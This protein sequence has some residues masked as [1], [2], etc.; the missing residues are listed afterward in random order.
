MLR[1]LRKS[2]RE[3]A[4][5]S[6]GA[7]VSAGPG[8]AQAPQPTPAPPMP[9]LGLLATA[10]APDAAV[11]AAM[12]AKARAVLPALAT[13]L[14]RLDPWQLAAA[15]APARRA[16]VRAQVG[17]GKTAVLAHRV[18]WLH[19]VH[20]VALERMAVTTFTTR[21]AA[22]LVDRLT[23]LLPEPP[24]AGAFRLFGTLHGVART[25]LLGELD[26]QPTGWRA[27]FGVL[28]E[29]SALDMLQTL[30]RRH[31]LDVKYPAQWLARLEALR[32]GRPV[33]R[34]N[35]RA[36]DDLAQL[37]ERYADE[38]RAQ[39]VMDFADLIA[40]AGDCV[41]RASAPLLAALVV[42]ELQDC[43]PAEVAL[44][45][46]L[47]ARS[48]HFFAVG[49]PNQSIYGWRGSSPHVFDDLSERLQCDSFVL[50]NNYRSTPEILATAQAALGRAGQGGALVA[51][52]AAGSRAVVLQHHTPQQEA[53]YL[54]RRFAHLHQA[55]A[56][57]RQMAVLAR[58]RRQLATVREHLQQQGVP[59]AD[60]PSG[61]WHDRPAAAWLLRLLAG[62]GPGEPQRLREALIDNRYGFG[63]AKLL[64][65]P[66][67]AASLALAD[68]SA[69]EFWRC[70]LQQ[71]PGSAGSQLQRQR[72]EILTFLANLQDLPAL[73]QPDVYQ[74]LEL[75]QRL[76]PTHRDHARD[77]RDVRQALRQ[78]ATARTKHP[79]WQEA[80]RALQAEGP[81]A[82]ADA[83]GVQLLT[84]HAAK[85]L[86]FDHVVVSGCNQGIIPLAAAYADPDALAEERRL[87]FVGLS[88]AR[89]TL[90]ISWHMQ[91]AMAQ[92]M[93]MPS[94]WLLALPAAVCRFADQ[95]ESAA[96]LVQP[97]EPTPPEDP[98]WPVG[99]AVR[100]AK[101]GAG[102]VLRSGD[103]EVLVDFGKLGQRPFSLLLCPLQRQAG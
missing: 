55:G 60:P 66:K 102:T 74:R 71:N 90:E 80:L 13:S 35:M 87:L 33:R 62:A 94:E 81:Q 93:A 30:V 79:S 73:D 51:T 49:D 22:Q 65:K 64:G 7:A 89:E 61:G 77:V 59:C 72:A 75:S 3:Q 24:P 57:F 84:L 88:R 39:N 34:G 20:G 10:E 86:E 63:T 46:A 5:A 2:L 56:P 43:A 103:G 26:L 54:A 70:H 16:V 100:H 29:D 31:N 41:A 1:D 40:Q 76:R 45:A 6:A 11:L 85:G 27:D 28:D 78:L 38:K 4:R 92:G 32:L 98:A 42:D 17:S 19:T 18:L 14:Q 53:M 47:A 44:V 83:D 82:D 48:D 15:T 99:C 68:A 101:Y 9:A 95:P 36:D 52:R 12:I 69:A 25:L 50:P 23:Q 21:A 96:P 97:A 8:P 91:P 58:T 67:P 37:A